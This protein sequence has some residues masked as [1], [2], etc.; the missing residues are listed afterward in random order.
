[1]LLCTHDKLFCWILSNEWT[2]L[3]TRGMKNQNFTNQL[4]KNLT[5]SKKNVLN[6]CRTCPLSLKL[7]S[8]W[9]MT[10]VIT[11][12]KMIKCCCDSF[13]DDRALRLPN[14]PQ[15]FPQSNDKNGI[16]RIAAETSRIPQL[17]FAIF[18]YKRR[19]AL[20]TDVVA[21]R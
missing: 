10:A 15:F 5:I 13:D 21:W 20:F 6:P 17:A 18:F 12:T 8:W 14:V 1:M 16:T 11:I 2:F 7:I 3:V 4:N 19:R 9:N